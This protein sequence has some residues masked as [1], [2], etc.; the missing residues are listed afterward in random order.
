MFILEQTA[1]DPKPARY[2]CGDCHHEI[3]KV[4]SVRNIEVIA[5]SN[6]SAF[7]KLMAPATV[8]CAFSPRSYC[9]QNRSPRWKG[10]SARWGSAA[11]SQHLA[12]F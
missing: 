2:N 6:T 8:Q 1:Q 9:L 11:R 5:I 3:G 12:V 4:P 10:Y 7:V